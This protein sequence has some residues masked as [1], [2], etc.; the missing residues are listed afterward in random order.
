MLSNQHSIKRGKN[1]TQQNIHT[2]NIQLRSSENTN[3]N[4]NTNIDAQDGTTFLTSINTELKNIITT[5]DHDGNQPPKDII[6]DHL[7]AMNIANDGSIDDNLK[8]IFSIDDILEQCSPEALHHYC[9]N[10]SD[11]MQENP[12]F[13][14]AIEK[15]AQ[16]DHTKKLEDFK[17]NLKSDLAQKNIFKGIILS[18]TLNYLTETI[19]SQ[20]EN[21]ER[22]CNHLE[23]PDSAFK[24]FFKNVK[25]F[26]IV[27]LKKFAV[28]YSI[29]KF[30]KKPTDPR[31]GEFLLPL[32]IFMM[33][34]F[35]T[36]ENGQVARDLS[37][38][39]A[40]EKSGQ[41]AEVQAQHDESGKISHL[42]SIPSL[43][44]NQKEYN[45]MYMSWNMAFVM[46]L[47][48][49]PQMMA[50][51]VNPA[52]AKSSDSPNFMYKRA[53]ALFLTFQL[54]LNK[55]KND[56]TFSMDSIVD[57]NARAIFGSANIENMQKFKEDIQSNPT[58]KNK[59]KL[60]KAL[61]G[62]FNKLKGRIHPDTK[63]YS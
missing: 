4:N 50:K 28:D 25:K 5:H 10:M 19:C 59:S 51:L 20:E 7:E 43:G 57:D 2:R 29:I 35:D 44:E 27:G 45:D 47:K 21:L 1:K 11:I 32:N 63:T 13:M 16:G 55:K 15:F 17:K 3:S 31:L 30:K 14:H 37:V 22:L 33:N 62:L 26:G 60:F 39:P 52:V 9:D 18:V 12:Y 41:A 46:S 48:Q 24:A 56:P 34:G 40:G 42:L 53:I 38:Y 54:L 58:R 6:I 49:W 23:L 8:D 61:T 36:K